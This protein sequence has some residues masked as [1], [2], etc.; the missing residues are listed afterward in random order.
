MAAMSSLFTFFLFFLS[1]TTI[2]QVKQVQAQPS[3]AQA[4]PPA[5][6]SCNGVFVSYTYMT[7]QKLPPD[8]KTNSV[9]QPYRFESQLFVINNGLQDL[10]SWRVFVGF[11]HGEWLVS[12]S[13]AVLA[14][15]TSLPG[16]V[17]NGTVFAGYPNSDL[18]TAIETAG[19]QTQMG[20]RIAL[21]GT[22]FGV[23]SPGVPMPQNISLVN[24][25]WVCPRPT[26]QGFI[27]FHILF[28]CSFLFGKIEHI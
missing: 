2:H 15:G 8:L 21:V 23:G 4:P 9:R 27:C 25:G 16:S 14:D 24:D 22:Q 6:D 1:L 12:A 17:E 11:Q 7:G 13:N 26:M 5:S 10:K 28:F 20:V 3:V 18:K 19:D